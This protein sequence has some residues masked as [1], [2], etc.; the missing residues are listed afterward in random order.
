MPETRKSGIKGLNPG[1]SIASKLLI[2]KKLNF[3]INCKSICSQAE[4][5]LHV[6]YSLSTKVRLKS[7]SIRPNWQNLTDFRLLFKVYQTDLFIG[8]TLGSVLR[9]FL[10]VR[11]T[12][13]TQGRLPTAS[14]CFNLLKLPNYSKKA[15]LKEG[16]SPN[17]DTN[18][19][20]SGYSK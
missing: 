4:L 18:N 10:S 11:K 17:Q 1:A 9:G 5:L 3:S 8:D 20:Y 13:V 15:T 7:I 14:T 12:K 19:Q 6:R 2:R 16:F